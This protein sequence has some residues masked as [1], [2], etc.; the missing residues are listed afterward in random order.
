MMSYPLV[1]HEGLVVDRTHVS[2]VGTIRVFYH[3]IWSCTGGCSTRA[4][5]PIAEQCA[6]HVAYVCKCCCI[7]RHDMH[8]LAQFV[9]AMQHHES[10][11]FSHK[12]CTGL[13]VFITVKL[14]PVD[15]SDNEKPNWKCM[16]CRITANGM[17]SEFSRH[18]MS[19]AARQDRLL[20]FFLNL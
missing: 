7:I 18:D 1:V 4:A 15:S 11:V 3:Q 16:E 14:N 19:R 12:S 20:Q 10:I 2:I 6:L 5:D 17:I 9:H 13:L 8:P